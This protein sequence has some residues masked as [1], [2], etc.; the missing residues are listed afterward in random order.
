MKSGYSFMVCCIFS[1]V[2]FSTGVILPRHFAIILLN[3]FSMDWRFSI[4]S[5]GI[6]YSVL[7]ISLIFLVLSRSHFSIIAGSPSDL[8]NV[9]QKL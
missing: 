8:L 4:Y 3:D 1:S 9:T 5:G 2:T 6:L 7:M